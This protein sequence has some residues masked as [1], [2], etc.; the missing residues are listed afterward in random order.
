MADQP[1]GERRRHQRVDVDLFTTLG[2][3]LADYAPVEIRIT[4]LSAGGL[5]FESAKP[6]TL[7]E[8]IEFDIPLRPPVPAKAFIG[9]VSASGPPFKHG[10]TFREFHQLHKNRLIAF[11]LEEMRLKSVEPMPGDVVS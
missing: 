2:G 6:F 4:N 11:L 3:T 10:A 1:E 7:G 9:W 5:G 8:L